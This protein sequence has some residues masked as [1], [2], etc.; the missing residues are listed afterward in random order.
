MLASSSLDAAIHLWDVDTGEKIRSMENGPMDAWTV[1]FRY[2]YI[3][4]ISL[5]LKVVLILF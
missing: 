3:A 1:A 5:R 4:H 2:A